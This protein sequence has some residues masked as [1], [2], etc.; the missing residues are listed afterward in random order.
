MPKIPIKHKAKPH[1]LDHR[2]YKDH[3]PSSFSFS[4]PRRVRSQVKSNKV[5]KTDADIWRVHRLIPAPLARSRSLCQCPTQQKPHEAG[6]V[7]SK[8]IQTSHP[9][10]S[11][12]RVGT[13]CQDPQA[14]FNSLIKGKG[15][16]L[17]STYVDPHGRVSPPF[18][19]GFHHQDNA[20]M[21][22][23]EAP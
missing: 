11:S 17:G 21:T 20:S 9:R 22:H 5:K 2:H 13:L 1:V 16:N 7:L 18:L 4:K 3:L 15:Q 23:L 14:L 10:R 8:R 19:V 6:Q 12:E